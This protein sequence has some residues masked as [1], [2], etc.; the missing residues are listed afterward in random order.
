MSTQPVWKYLANL[1]DA[2][3]LLY[4]GLFVYTDET[5]VYPPEAELLLEPADDIDVD[6]PKARWTVFRFILEPCTY[7][8]GVLSD[9]KYHPNKA[10]W[11]AKDLPSL[12]SF[13]GMELETL[14]SLFTSADPCQRAHA[15]QSVGDYWG[16]DNLDS[17][18][19]K[20]TRA[21]IEAR[22]TDGE[23]G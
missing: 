23:L 21:E 17:Y 7:I 5:G 18:P 2:T 15:W 12:A 14:I 1:G 13:I 9:N 8:N 3:P 22:Y 16:F 20:Y 11:F 19:E 10:A 6:S 4:G